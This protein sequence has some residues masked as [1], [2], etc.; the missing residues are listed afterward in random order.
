MPPTLYCLAGL[1]GTGKTTIAQLLARQSGAV[2]LRVDEI[3]AAIWRLAPDRD[4]GPES[5][6]IAAALAA[7]NCELGHDA[8]VDCVNP[9]PET[10]RIF[11]EAAG[12]AGARLA[13]VEVVCSDP[14]V[15]RARL[16][17][18]DS[19]LPGQIRR[20]WLLE[21]SRDYIP[22][23]DADVRLDT[24]VLAQEDGVRRIRLALAG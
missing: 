12:R 16:E 4:I 11:A 21:M 3:D 20:D 8:V 5:Y 19:A 24:A 7:S 23:D 15:L 2:Y 14:A 22:W 9:W 1:P 17:G 18:R 10:R 13:A 6:H